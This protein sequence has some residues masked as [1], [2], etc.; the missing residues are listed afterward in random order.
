MTHK[1]T[2]VVLSLFHW[3]EENRK[4]SGFTA[5]CP[6]IR[7]VQAILPPACVIIGVSR[8]WLI[9][10]SVRESVWYLKSDTLWHLLLWERS[11]GHQSRSRPD[12]CSTENPIGFSPRSQLKK[13]CSSW[14]SPCFYWPPMTFIA[15]CG[16]NTFF[17]PIKKLSM[18]TGRS[19]KCQ[20]LRCR[21][22]SVWNALSPSN[23]FCPQIL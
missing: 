13:I 12:E 15:C 20:W 16:V 17:F 19:F 11:L 6:H 10:C 8:L 3:R 9:C 2:S 5:R 14:C 21:C 22:W 4:G 18:V 1:S 7:D 23:P